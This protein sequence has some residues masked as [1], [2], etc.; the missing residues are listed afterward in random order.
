MTV[1][2]QHYD[3]QIK[4]DKVHSFSKENFTRAEI[5]WLLNEAQT[6]FIKQRYG[7]NNTKRNGFET[8]QKRIDDLKSLHIKF[9]L[10]P[11]LN[12]LPHS[13]GIYEVDLSDLVYEYM[14]LT[15]ATAE[16]VKPACVERAT[17][18]Q[19]Q[20]DDLSEVLNDPFNKP[21]DFSLPF[22]FGRASDGISDSIYIYTDG[23]SLGNVYLEYIKEPA[24]INYGGYE[25][26]DG[27]TY[28][29]QD[30][31]LSFPEEIVDLAVSIASGIIEHP[32][33]VQ[34]KQQKVFAH[35]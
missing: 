10:Q 32:Q 12:P 25:Y 8:S 9:P 14:F 22:N 2:E 31:E 30:C 21:D 19:I 17:L 1:V 5:D 35:E 7:L 15:R 4:I 16:V 28:P 11:G 3:F 13:D 34:L 26:I 33:Y 23:Q 18:K 6:V 24:R 27:V 29:P 20:N